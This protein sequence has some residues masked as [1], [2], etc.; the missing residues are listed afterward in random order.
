M[1]RIVFST[2]L[3]TGQIVN[4]AKNRY[5]TATHIT[6]VRNILITAYNRGVK[7]DLS[8][9]GAFLGKSRSGIVPLLEYLDKIGFTKRCGNFRQVSTTNIQNADYSFSGNRPQT[10]FIGNHQKE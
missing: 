3:K 6:H 9:I 7:L 2:L 5:F 10:V 4:I 8:S 1:S